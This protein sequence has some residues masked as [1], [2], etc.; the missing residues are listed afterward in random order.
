MANV[1]H[2]CLYDP[3]S[4]QNVLERILPELGE[5]K[6]VVQSTTIDP[7]SA[8]RFAATVREAGARYVEAPFTGSK[9]AARKRQTVFY[10]GGEANDLDRVEPVLST[11][12]RKC[13]RLSRPGQAAT[14]KLAMN[15]QI[16]AITEALCGG[17]AWSRGAGLADDEFFDVLRENVAWSGLA[18]LKEPKIRAGDFSPQF[19]IRNMHKDM[20]LASE[21][22][23]LDLPLLPF[24][25]E[26]LRVAEEAGFGEDDFASLLRLLR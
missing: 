17:V 8:E 10:L 7:D 25:R 6:T 23:P 14:I 18:E 4:V 5:G 13:F 15:L 1:V 2:L 9:P 26:R 22:C 19:T 12:S 11:L 20:R 24:V 21:S 3:A 16:S